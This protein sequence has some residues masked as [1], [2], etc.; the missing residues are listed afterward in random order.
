LHLKSE[1]LPANLPRSRCIGKG[2]GSPDRLAAQGL[3]DI[4]FFVTASG[5]DGKPSAFKEIGVMDENV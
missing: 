1:K 5:R 3:R 4:S 2:Y